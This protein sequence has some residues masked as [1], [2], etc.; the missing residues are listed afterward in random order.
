MAKQSSFVR[1]LVFL[2]LSVLICLSSGKNSNV[3]CIQRER[4]ALLNFKASLNDPSNRLSSWKGNDC[5]LWN[6]IICSNITGHVIKLDLQNPCNSV[7]SQKTCSSES[8]ELEDRFLFVTVRKSEL[9]GL[10]WKQFF[11]IVQF[12]PSSDP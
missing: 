12:L 7:P 9:F 2:L 6:G 5:C 1:N 8:Y 3:G 10:K 11:M 4:N